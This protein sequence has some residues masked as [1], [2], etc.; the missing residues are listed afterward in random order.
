MLTG[1]TAK[2]PACLASAEVG[3][4][5]H[6]EKTKAAAQAMIKTIRIEALL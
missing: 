4:F 3:M 2:S 1:L 5:D 6:A